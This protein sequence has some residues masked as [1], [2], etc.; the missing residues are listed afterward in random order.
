MKIQ[1][2]LNIRKVIS[3][4]FV[5]TL[6]LSH[7][8]FAQTHTQNSY[9]EVIV[10]NV[11]KLNLSKVLY[12]IDN[13]VYSYAEFYKLPADTFENFSVLLPKEAKK[14]YGKIA[15]KGL[16]TASIRKQQRNDQNIEISIQEPRDTTR[17]DETVY[18]IVEQMPQFLSGTTDMYNYIRE[19]LKNPNPELHGRVIVQFVVDKDGSVKNIKILRGVCPEL[20]NAAIRLLQNMPK[21][22][23]GKQGGKNVKVTLT[24][25]IVFSAN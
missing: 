2:E 11:Y 1:L 24:L 10:D 18:V 16:I 9:K 19:N 13:N 14:K 15:S 3:I 5:V 20:D 4:I 17:S 8:S 23:P 25:P 12:M 21:W 7:K 22:T 6:F